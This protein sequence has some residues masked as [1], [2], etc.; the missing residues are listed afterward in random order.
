[1]NKQYCLKNGS[2]WYPIARKW[3][4]SCWDSFDSFKD[5]I[6]AYYNPTKEEFDEIVKGDNLFVA[7][8]EFPIIYE[9]DKYHKF[10][11]YEIYRLE[12]IV[13]FPSE[14]TEL[15]IMKVVSS[16]LSLRNTDSQIIN[17][18]KERELTKSENNGTS[19]YIYKVKR[20]E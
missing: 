3:C 11:K 19:I 7:W 2:E 4:N 5:T 6:V 10:N 18:F 14:A 12:V 8:E 1:M 17:F 16:E 9:M 15:D 20:K 13:E